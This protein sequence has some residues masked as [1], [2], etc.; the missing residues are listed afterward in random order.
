[1]KLSQHLDNAWCKLRPGGHHSYPAWKDS[2]ETA[3]EYRR[4]EFCGLQQRKGP[5]LVEEISGMLKPGQEELDALLGKQEGIT[6]RY[7]PPLS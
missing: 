6:G 2:D 3:R 4:C 1:M 7:P 5:T